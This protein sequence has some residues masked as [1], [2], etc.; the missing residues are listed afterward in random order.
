MTNL[1]D[2]GQEYELSHLE[3]R[4]LNPDPIEQFRKWI[5]EAIQAAVKE[6]NAMALATVSPQGQPHCRMVLLKYFDERGFVFFSNYESTK[7]ND[8]NHNPKASLTFWWP[9]FERQV[10]IEG[11]ISKLDSKHSDEYF[12][13]RDPESNLAAT[14]SKQSQILTNKQLFVDEFDNQRSK[15]DDS[16]PMIRPDHW[17]GY[18]LKPHRMEF[19][20]G[21]PHRLHDRLSYNHD[22]NAWN[23]VR[24]YP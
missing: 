7:G 14:L 15:L 3:E 22:S 11:T 9:D 1:N 6:P 16:T 4:D 19:W 10:R 2:L 24:L 12:A 21:G 17:G 8:L 13:Q 18:I 5:S 20:Q 23:I